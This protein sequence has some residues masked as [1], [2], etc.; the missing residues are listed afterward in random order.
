M[1]LEAAH[2]NRMAFL[3]CCL[4][5][6][7]IGTGDLKSI[8]LS[9]CF[10]PCLVPMLKINM[11]RKLKRELSIDIQGMIGRTEEGTSV[12]SGEPFES[13]CSNEACPEVFTGDNTADL[14]LMEGEE[15]V[16]DADIDAE[17]TPD[18]KDIDE[19][20]EG[21]SG[22]GLEG[23]PVHF[24]SGRFWNYINYML[25]LLCETACKHTSMKEEFEKGI[26]SIMVQIFQD[27]LLDCPSHRKVTRLVVVNPQWQTTIQ[28][29]L[30][31]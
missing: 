6:F 21:D 20:S 24:N 8:P 25:N 3:H 9:D 29:G 14:G 15:E 11:Q 7:L 18:T 17:G 19:L 26:A 27:D 30:M 31:W 5:I 12:A 2:W 4:C 23:K 16:D 1:E 13:T 10:T 22:F 28:H